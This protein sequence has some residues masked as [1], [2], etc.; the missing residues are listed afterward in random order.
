[1][2]NSTYDIAAFL[3]MGYPEFGDIAEWL[4]GRY[5]VA[6]DPF[7][8]LSLNNVV[9][10]N[11]WNRLDSDPVGWE[12]HKRLYGYVTIVIDLYRRISVN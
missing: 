4:M 6:D 3:E 12:Y 2:I 10:S 7:E 8:I 11:V 1:M 9:N 5:V